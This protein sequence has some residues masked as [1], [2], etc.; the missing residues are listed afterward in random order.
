MKRS[1][2]NRIIQEGIQFLKEYKFILPPFAYWSPKEWSS[3]GK[4]YDEI[5]DNQ[6]GWDITDF[7][8]DD[9][10]KQGLFLFTLR[11]GNQNMDI[12]TKP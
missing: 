3:K 8:S 12:Y 6:L 5:R 9:F 4:E 1:E 10:T 7:G 2:I 11:N